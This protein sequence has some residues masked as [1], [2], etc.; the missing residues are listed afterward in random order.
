[1][2]KLDKFS[3]FRYYLS[4][5]K[6][7]AKR[8][9]LDFNISLE[10]LYSQWQN[11]SGRCPISGLQ[12]ILENSSTSRNRS[13]ASAKTASLDRKDSLAGYIKG[14]IQFVCYSINLAKNNLTE[15]EI[16]DFINEIK[17]L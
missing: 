5:A 6:K 11:Q 16:I 14:N 13:I 1:M 15:K 10:D 9:R 4:E 8:K 17:K 2:K 7:S 12:M 3:P